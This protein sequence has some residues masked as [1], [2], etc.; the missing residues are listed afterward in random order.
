MASEGGCKS[1][2]PRYGAGGN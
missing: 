2:Q 1:D